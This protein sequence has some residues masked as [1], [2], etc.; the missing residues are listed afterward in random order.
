MRVNGILSLLSLCD[1][2][3][4]A[5]YFYNSCQRLGRTSASK[6]KGGPKT[7]SY[8]LCQSTRILRNA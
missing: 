3:E 6:L 7:V 4:S 2:A 5:L 8:F 1:E